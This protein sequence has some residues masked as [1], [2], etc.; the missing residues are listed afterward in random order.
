MTNRKTAIDRRKLMRLF[1]QGAAGSLAL[2]QLGGVPLFGSLIDGMLSNPL[3]PLINHYDAF[4]MMGNALSGGPAAL[5]VARAMAEVK[6]SWVLV[7]IKVCNH[8]HTPMVFR[9]GKLD[10]GVVTTAADVQLASARMTGAK[11]KLVAQGIDLIS[12]NPRYQKL[13]FN[14]WFANILHN[15]T[16]DGAAPVAANLNGLDPGDV[17]PLDADKVAVQAFLGL[18]QIDSN[19]H[20]LKGCKLRAGLPDLTKF[21]LDKKIITSPLG[22]SCFMMGGNYDKA[23]GAI[24]TNAVLGEQLTETAIVTSRSVAAYVGQIGQFVGKS[25]ADR[26][27]IEQNVIYRMDKLV[28]KDPVLRRDLVNSIV[29]FQQGLGSLNAAG[30]LEGT[31]QILDATT[32]NAQAKGGPGENGAS[33]EFLAQCKYVAASLELPGTPVRNFSLFLNA[34]DLDGN[35]LDKGYFGGAGSGVKALSYVEAMRQLGM[36]LNILGKRIAAGKKMIIVVHSEGGRGAAM[37]DSKT[38]FALVMGPKGTGML[39]DELYFNKA[40][41]DIATSTAV[42]DMAAGTSAMKW[43]MDGFMSADGSKADDVPSTGDVQMGVVEFL[44]EQTGTNARAG[45]TGTDGRFVKLKRA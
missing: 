32:G 29:Q 5:G 10:A 35:D 34:S 23:E 44:E 7:Q 9:L 28:Q 40:A 36:G 13:R 3:N 15:G 12:D 25:Y 1:V 30:D 17:A 6:D 8:V 37:D 42:K 31:F 21:V 27:P 14:K 41:T 22:I 4:A 26:A 43:D 11:Q 33:C 2:E 18:K 20:A 39:A 19:N 16:S 24:P 45:L 38:S